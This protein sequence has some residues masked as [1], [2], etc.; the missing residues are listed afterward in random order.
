MSEVEQCRNSECGKRYSVSEIGG[1]MPGTKESED[2]SCPYCGN[3]VTRRSNG[4]FITSKLPN[5]GN[6]KD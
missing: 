3:V 2:I 4:S 1:K 5:D 6:A